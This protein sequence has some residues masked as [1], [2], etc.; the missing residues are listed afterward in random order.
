ME[1]SDPDEVRS[2]APVMPLHPRELV[3]LRAEV[4]N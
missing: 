4:V 3:Q 1:Y 2:L